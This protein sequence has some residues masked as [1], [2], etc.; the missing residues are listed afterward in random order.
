D[1]LAGGRG[2]AARHGGAARGRARLARGSRKRSAPPPLRADQQSRAHAGRDRAA[3]Q[4][5]ARARP[6][7]RAA[8]VRQAAQGE[9]IN[10]PSRDW[11]GIGGAGE[12]TTSV[13]SLPST[14]RSQTPDTR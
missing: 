9:L 10:D 6:P 3:P 1:C 14:L 12:R 5:L 4:S 8:R 2:A 13:W 11:Y 7:D